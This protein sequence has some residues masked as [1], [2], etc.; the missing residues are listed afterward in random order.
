MVEE[1][2]A[3]PARAVAAVA[4][5]GLAGAH[6]D[7]V[8]VGLESAAGFVDHGHG[9]RHVARHLDLEGA[10]GLDG[11]IAED[12]L[13]LEVGLAN[14]LTRAHAALGGTARTTRTETRGRSSR[15]AWR[16]P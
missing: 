6:L 15:Q 8:G 4:G 11:R 12:L 2:S 14:G 10:I 1:L 16:G 9:Q 13:G 5:A 3:A 7:P